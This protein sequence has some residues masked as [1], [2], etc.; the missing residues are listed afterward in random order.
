MPD[1]KGLLLVAHD[2]NSGLD[3]EGAVNLVARCLKGP[4]HKDIDWLIYLT[5]NMSVGLPG[6]D[7][8][9]RPIVSAPRYHPSEFPK[10]LPSRIIDKWQELD[11]AHFGVPNTRFKG[12]SPEIL[13]HFRFRR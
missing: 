7:R 4:Y 2:G 6:S 10:E 3:P 1:A 11:S 9:V 13:D 12:T 8:I 5:A